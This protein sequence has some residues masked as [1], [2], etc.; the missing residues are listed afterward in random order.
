MGPSPG[1][2]RPK[3]PVSDLTTDQQQA[4]IHATAAL[5]RVDAPEATRAG[6]RSIGLAVQ[7]GPQGATHLTLDGW[8]ARIRLLSPGAPRT[9]ATTFTAATG[10][11]THDD[12]AAHAHAAVRAWASVLEIRRIS[13]DDLQPPA[14]W[15]RSRPV[16]AVSLALE[17]ASMPPA[18]T[19]GTGRC[20]HTGYRV[21]EGPTDRSARVEW[22]RCPEDSTKTDPTEELSACR[23]AL[24]SRGWN[25]ER[26]LGARHHPYLVVWP[27]GERA[28]LL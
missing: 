24:H 7:H 22:K 20:L 11:G 10:H 28:P 27:N 6:L 17:A 4:L 1:R 2:R 16:H 25:S 9:D 5:G 26:Y 3:A 19:S 13:A 8:D 12:R 18:E 21:V 14:E 23:D 15:E